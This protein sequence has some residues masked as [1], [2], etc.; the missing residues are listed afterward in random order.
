[1]SEVLFMMLF[2]TILII[3]IFVAIARWIFRINTIV[4]RLDSI[5]EAVEGGKP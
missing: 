1:M 4:R 3:A 5:L 2:W